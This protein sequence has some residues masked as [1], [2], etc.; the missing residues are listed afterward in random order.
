MVCVDNTSNKR[1]LVTT[2]YSRG[3]YAYD[4]TTGKVPLSTKGV[5]AC[6]AGQNICMSAV[7]PLEQSVIRE[8]ADIFGTLFI[9]FEM[10]TR[11]S[12]S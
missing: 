12:G 6:D 2:H 4:T 1:L 5:A 11:W 9:F 8:N 3:V 7:S 10:C